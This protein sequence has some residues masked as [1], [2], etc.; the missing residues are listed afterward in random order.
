[1][2]LTRDDDAKLWLGHAQIIQRDIMA[3]N[4]VIHIIDDVIV[5]EDGKWQQ[6]PGVLYVSDIANHCSF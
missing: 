3:S 4:G 5:P 6:K 1:M 2:N